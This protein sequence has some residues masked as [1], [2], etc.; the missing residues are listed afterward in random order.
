MKGFPT[1]FASEGFFAI[2][3]HVR[4]DENRVIVDGLSAFT[5]LIGLLAGVDMGWCMT[6]DL[7]L[8][9]FPRS[10]HLQGFSPV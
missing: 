6:C 5:A 9:T 1:L 8:K 4:L 10:M 7:Q 2:V 3:G